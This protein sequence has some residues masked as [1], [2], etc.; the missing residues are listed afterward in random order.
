[1]R[2]PMI[3]QGERAECG[4]ACLAMVLA[5]HGDQRDLAALRRE[6]PVATNGASLAD[7]V[8]IARAA[9]L[10]TRSLRAEPGELEQLRLPCVLHWDF[11]HFVVLAR[12]GAQGCV[13]HDPA[14]GVRRFAVAELARRFTGVA[15]ELAPG[16]GFRT[17]DTRAPLR[18]R[19]LLPD[20]AGLTGAL[21]QV[22]LLSLLVQASVLASPYFIQLVVDDVLAA[23]NLDLLLVLGVGFGLVGLVGV[24]ATAL[25]GLLVGRFGSVLAFRMGAGLMR[26]LLRLPPGY[27]TSRPAGD[28]VARFNAFDE[29]RA[30]VSDSAAALLIDALLVFGFAAILLLYDVRLA[31]IVFA[32]ALLHALL[33][34]GAYPRQRELAREHLARSADATSMLLENLRSA[35]A[36]KSFGREDARLDTWQGRFLAE[37]GARL[38]LQRLA[39]GVEAGRGASSAIEQVLVLYLAAVAVF[40][41]SLTIGMLFAFASY[42]GQFRDRAAALVDHLFGLRALDVQ[43]ERLA[44]IVRTPAERTE[45]PLALAASTGPV[46]L[47]VSDLAYRHPGT[48]QALL[49]RVGFEIPAG[50]SI[51]IVGPSGSGKSTLLRLVAGLLQPDAG[52]IELLGLDPRTAPLGLYRSAAAIVCQDDRPLA[53]TVVQNVTFFD[54]VP[55]PERVRDCLEVVGLFEELMAQPMRLETLVGELG[56][57]LSAG[58]QQ[59]VLIAR[60]LY[61]GA[62]LLIL[63][64]ATANVD[65]VLEDHL[66][67]RLRER[68]QTV[69]FVTHRPHLLGHADR[70]YR[71]AGG[72]LHTL[73]HP[74]AER[75]RAG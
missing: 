38:S 17:A 2:V 11:D 23:G 67:A 18:L 74:A 43:L 52:Q 68:R 69:L 3:H 8:R 70:V 45:G 55:D 63:D 33:R 39:V 60:A 19:E 13:I 5:A 41:G 32:G 12:I 58:Q 56:A 30:F 73:E 7:L 1:M 28:V 47:R 59:R 31:A 71:L 72:E 6:H 29:V 65:V 57:S 36:I 50:Q 21:A 54:P 16:P 48:R 75:A 42:R 35:Q 20:R 34:I 26:H 40:E 44:D 37:L 53:G 25:R 24:A 62:P 27:Y 64:E 15:L 22:V 4:L 61:K 51:A 14:L 46:L 49:E 66:H 10:V 9:G